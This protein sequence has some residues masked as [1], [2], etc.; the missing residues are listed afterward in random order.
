VPK[1]GEGGKVGKGE[2]HER[3]KLWGFIDFEYRDSESDPS[4]GDS[5]GSYLPHHTNLGVDAFLSE[6]WDVGVLL[7]YS[8]GT[9][10]VTAQYARARWK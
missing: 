6:N 9:G 4:P 7:E 5:D 3:I 2:W 8:R 1:P 10:G